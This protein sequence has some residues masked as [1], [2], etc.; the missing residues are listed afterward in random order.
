MNVKARV[1]TAMFA[2]AALTATSAHAKNMATGE[3]IRKLVSG[4][5]VQGSMLVDKYQKYSEY[6]MADGTIKGD[7]YNGKWTIEGDTMCFAYGGNSSGCWAA[8]IEGPAI[9]WWKDGAVDGA[10]VARPGNGNNY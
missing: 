9:I 5:T 1:I 2:V 6:Y 10:A 8:S 4:S 3:E 7:G